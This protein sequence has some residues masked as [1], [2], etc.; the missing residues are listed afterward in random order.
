M[1]GAER[2]VAQT[3]E[4][5]RPAADAGTGP[6]SGSPSTGRPPTPDDLELRRWEEG[7]DN[8]GDE[9]PKFDVALNDAAHR[10]DDAHTV[11]RHGPDVPLRR[12]PTMRTIEGRIYGDTGWA[13]PM[14]A[15]FRWTDH[16][17]MN[18]TVNDYVR[19][20]WEQIRNNLATDGVHQAT[21]D[22]GHRIGEGFVNTG[23]GGAGPRRAQYMTT[24]VVRILIAIAPGTDP[25]EPFIVTAFPAGLG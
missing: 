20:H 9:P 21:F 18:R 13:R 25:P 16:S 11:D 23:M 5:G 6:V 3:F 12:D 2:A 24:S 8:L 10:A 15:S 19:A 4:R 22:A 1:A 17:T 14:N 7:Y